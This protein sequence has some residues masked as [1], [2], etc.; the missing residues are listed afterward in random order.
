MDAF[1]DLYQRMFGTADPN[2][3]VQAAQAERDA[4][5]KKLADAEAAAKLGQ[6]GTIGNTPDGVA[7]TTGAKR[8]HKTRKGGRKRKSRR[9][10]TGRKSTRS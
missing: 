3:A 6:S 8:K 2:A 1:K 4:A 9:S 7:V 5:N 10:R